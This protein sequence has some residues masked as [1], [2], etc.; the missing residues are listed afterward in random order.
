MSD[1]FTFFPLMFYLA[2]QWLYGLSTIPHSCIVSD[3]P[4]KQSHLYYPKKAFLVDIPLVFLLCCTISIF[5]RSL[6]LVL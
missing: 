5:C 4:E 3:I 1:I 2:M 6:D